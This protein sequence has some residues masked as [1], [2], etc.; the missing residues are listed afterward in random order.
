M[1]DKLKYLAVS[2]VW[3]AF[4]LLPIQKNKI[5]VSNFYG[6]PFGD[7]PKAIVN[8]LLS[9]NLDLDIVWLADSR[10][11]NLNLP[12]GVRAAPYG[13]LSRIRELMTAKVWVDDCR[14]G[15]HV[16]RKGQWYLQ[17]WHGFAIKRCEGDAVDV[18]PPEYPAYAARDSAQTDLVLTGSRYMTDYTRKY[19]W[20]TCDIAEEG[21]PRND[22]LFHPT[23]ALRKQVYAF[24]NIP[25]HKKIA[26][27]AP[28]FRA[29]GS[30]EP[31]A[32]DCQGVLRA[33][34]ERFGGE[35][36]L[37][38]RLHPNIQDK[39]EQLNLSGDNVIQAT[40]YPDLQ[41]L[42]A[43]ADVTITDYSSLIVDYA[44]TRRPGFLFATD[45][46]AYR[47]DRDLAVPLEKLPFQMNESNDELTAC[48]RDFDD[49]EYQ[50]RLEEFFTEY[51]FAEQGHAAKKCVDWILEHLK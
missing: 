43:L 21:T 30:L 14:K 32:L 13:G 19:F 7:N 28:T 29:D 12:D 49:G 27:Y 50:R 1:K 33:C 15:A 17:T 22:V 38:V 18:L 40:N 39:A 41:E 37:L 8:E 34:E 26:I 10:Y 24:L 35:F 23:E 51:G 4:R 3:N 46:A 16:K 25:E 42:L 31:Y 47:Q 2:M 5:V 45:L 36:V 48:I 9:R 11:P 6:R 20:Y 44:L